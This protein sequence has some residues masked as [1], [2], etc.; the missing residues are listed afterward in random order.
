MAAL[1]VKAADGDLFP[2]P[3]PHEGLERL[4]E[5]CDYIII[6][7]WR[8]C[9]FKSAFSKN[10]A[11]RSTFADWI[12][13]MPYANADTV[14][15]AINRL[16]KTVSKNGKHTLAV[17]QMARDF[18][19]SD[20][21]EFRSAEIFLPFAKAV[22]NHKKI[23]AAD[24]APFASLIRKIENVQKGKPLGRLEFVT[25]E[26]TKA[27]LDNFR[28]QIVAVVIGD[29]RDSQG[30]FD[31]V[32]MSADNNMTALIDRGLLTVLY[33]YPGEN[34]RDWLEAST[35]FPANWTS[36]AWAEAP[37]W[38][39][40]TPP[41]TIILLDGRHKVLARDL[42]VNDLL[43]MMSHLRNQLIVGQ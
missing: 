6:N 36:G 42:T 34:D 9:D 33:I 15:V 1:P 31:R 14:H 26:G 7:F 10:E 4:D 11:L 35:K 22:V 28:T 43:I 38:F 41:N 29:Y 8:Q 24:K 17:A 30:S 32:R 19:Y 3:Q 12:G 16:L 23:S 27:N 39:E 40:L 20:S 18:T 13:F 2:Y 5:R 25:P 37:D 21:S